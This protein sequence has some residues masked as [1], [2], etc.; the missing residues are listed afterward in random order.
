[1]SGASSQT[2][3]GQRDEDPAAVTRRRARYIPPERRAPG[4]PDVDFTGVP[5]DPNKN[6]AVE[7]N[8]PA[9]S[10]S[11]SRFRGAGGTLAGVFLGGF[12]YFLGVAFLR[13][14]PRGARN[15]M[16]AKFLNKTAGTLTSSGAS[17]PGAIA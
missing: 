14:G 10:P 17:A 1:M 5:G 12:A 2:G 8:S 3:P 11:P 13:G 6:A 7:A 16:A 15:W 4:G 9:P